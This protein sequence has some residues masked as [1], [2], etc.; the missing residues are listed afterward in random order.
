M[1]GSVLPIQFSTA[2]PKSSRTLISVYLSFLQSLVKFC[3]PFLLMAPSSLTPPR[4][5]ASLHLSQF[6]E[7]E[8]S[9][10][11]LGKSGTLYSHLDF[12]G[13]CCISSLSYILSF[14]ILICS[15]SSACEYAQVS[16]TFKN[17]TLFLIFFKLL[18]PLLAKLLQ[19][20]STFFL[21][22]MVMFNLLQSVFCLYYSTE[23]LLIAKFDGAFWP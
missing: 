10:F 7:E 20:V 4:N 15:F 5:S 6:S 12:P 2:L 16:F 23:D 8:G 9:C 13:F 18:L 19:S 22:C 11:Y 1:L 17:S 21:S 14:S 3:P